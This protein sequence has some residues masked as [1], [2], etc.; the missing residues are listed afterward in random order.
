M[1]STEG[2]IGRLFFC[3]IYII[4]MLFELDVSIAFHCEALCFLELNLRDFHKETYSAE[5][6]LRFFPCPMFLRNSFS[7]S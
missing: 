4:T 3:V 1:R 7:F 5:V 6:Y 2:S